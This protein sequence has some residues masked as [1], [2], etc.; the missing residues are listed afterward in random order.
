[1]TQAAHRWRSTLPKPTTPGELDDV[2]VSWSV[3]DRILDT[4]LVIGV[5]GEG[6]MGR[7]YRARHLNWGSDLAVK[8]PLPAL[9]QTDRDRKRFIAE[10]D[11]WVGIGLH[12]NICACHYVRVLGGVPRVFAEYVAG[13]TLQD[14]LGRGRP[15]QVEVL[16]LAIQLG[17]ALSRAH[18]LG[19]LHLDVKPSNVLLEPDGIVKLADFGLARAAGALRGVSGMSIAYA[20][21][22][23]LAYARV[24]QRADVWS[25]AATVLAY[26]LGGVR[27]ENGSEAADAV[28]ELRSRFSGLAELL[29]GCLRLKREQ[30]T[31]SIAAVT[32]ELI[33]L[34]RTQTG[35]RY[36]RSSADATERRADELN[37]LALTLLDLGRYQDAETAFG[38][39]RDLDA[40]HPEATYNAGVLDWRSGLTTDDR[41]LED[42]N[43]A[44]ASARSSA[45]I[46]AVGAEQCPAAGAL[47][48][49]SDLVTAVCPLADGSV[50][51]ASQDGTVR[52]WDP[53]SNQQTGRWGDGSMPFDSLRTDAL[54]EV[55]VASG[56]MDGVQAWDI[57]TGALRWKHKAKDICAVG[58]GPAGIR[59]VTAH[60]L[61]Q[62]LRFWRTDGGVGRWWPRS[63][64][65]PI[66]APHSVQAH[67]AALP[68][69]ALA[70]DD[71][72]AV[73]GPRGEVVGIEPGDAPAWGRRCWLT[74]IGTQR[75]VPLGVVAQEDGTVSIW[76]LPE[77]Q[78]IASCPGHTPPVG[79]VHL[80]ASGEHLVTGDAAG[81]IRIWEVTSGRL[82][83]RVEGH[84]G[85][86]VAMAV[87]P[88]TRYAITV[89]LGAEVARI[90]DLDA[91]RCL[92][93]VALPRESSPRGVTIPE[94]A[95]AVTADGKYALVAGPS[96]SV[97]IWRLQASPAGPLRPAR[98]SAAR[99]LHQRHSIAVAAVE[100]GERA[101]SAGRFAEALTA[102]TEARSQPGYERD[103]ALM[104]AW[105]QLARHCARV[106]PVDGWQI[107][108]RPR[109][110]EDGGHRSAVTQDGTYVVECDPN[111]SAVRVRDRLTGDLVRA[112]PLGRSGGAD[113][114][115]LSADDRWLVTGHRL[116]DPGAR[117]WNF[118]TG[119]LVRRL[120]A[121]RVN[122]VAVDPGGAHVLTDGEDGAV[123]IWDLE[124]GQCEL[125]LVG[126]A[127]AV[128]AV[129]FGA[130]SDTV[131]S[132]GYDR[133]VRTWMLDWKL[134]PPDQD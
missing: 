57:R 17:R 112:I 29:H 26:A 81:T 27:W 68:G 65:C 132:T 103:P 20:A 19:V 101:V 58:V 119:R 128:L 109:G 12:P 44:G 72:I 22:E 73:M 83:S 34:Y 92:R 75:L 10:I 115:G 114:L 43:A 4:Y 93:T 46:E 98:P 126:H 47:T 8:V 79:S 71:G 85:P 96:R 38:Q 66:G 54:E 130:N 70:G 11:A 50:L 125:T 106:R 3:G 62:R 131:T 52:H 6:G 116:T 28:P 117:L 118:K 48:G 55:L 60:F 76:R 74:P 15:S 113:A 127:G 49:H 59:I 86:V 104:A 91:G 94:A 69:A 2:P 45:L 40:H 39:V 84:R 97:R 121:G 124:T 133:T 78:K 18:E 53:G 9:F 63:V 5:L 56:T 14:R 36:P 25:F 37:N 88:E 42:L 13:G 122:A 80:D 89:Q 61:S 30:R 24:D 35:E 7:V 21:P 1:M 99:V 105:H 32:D 107:A 129:A 87:G 120:D 95:V 31:S 16:D 33:E 100:A 90:W 108:A 123:R 77:M 110:G 64:P 111:D 82:I 67:L 41:L 23:Q 51:T 102:L 134:E